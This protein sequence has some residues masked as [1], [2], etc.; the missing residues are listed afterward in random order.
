MMHYRI[1]KGIAVLLSNMVATP[2]R[3][4]IATPL[5]ELVSSAKDR[6]IA[7]GNGRPKSGTYPTNGRTAREGLG[8]WKT[9]HIRQFRLRLARAG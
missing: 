7:E 9:G 5:R 6:K 2:E 4:E 8:D 1:L 3:V